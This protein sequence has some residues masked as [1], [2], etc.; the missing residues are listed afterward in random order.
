MAFGTRVVFDAIRELDFG[1][2]SGTY[3]AIGTPLSDHVRIISFSNGTDEAVYISS[4]GSTDNLRL[5]GNS[6][7]LLDL[8]ANKI[9]D[10]GLFLPI[11]LQFYVKEVSS[12]PTSGSVWIEVLYAEGGK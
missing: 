1:D 12:S 9:R 2:I 11:G 8:S 3:A 4:D 5:R 10:D 6:F 7:K